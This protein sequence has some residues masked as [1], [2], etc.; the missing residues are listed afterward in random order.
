MIPKSVFRNLYW[1]QNAVFAK[2]GIMTPTLPQINKAGW[3][4]CIFYTI[5]LLSFEKITFLY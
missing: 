4:C 1:Q 3:R 2:P 5:N